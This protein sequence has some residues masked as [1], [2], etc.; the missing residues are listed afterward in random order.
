MS[1]TPSYGDKVSRIGDFIRYPKRVLI[2]A[3]Q[4]GF[5]EEYLFTDTEG[6]RVENPFIY[7]TD[8][9]GETT[10]DSRIEIADTWT[11]ELKETDPRPIITVRRS[12]LSFNR[13]AIGGLGSIDLPGGKWKKFTI[14]MDCPIIAN[15]WSRKDLESEEIAMAVAFFFSLFRETHLKR[16][17]LQSLSEPSIGDTTPVKVDAE[18]ELFVTPVQIMTTMTL[19]W[20]VNY[21][22]L[23][24][25]KGVQINTNESGRS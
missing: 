22:A 1:S 23:A 4:I 21:T 9:N 12:V 16:T 18:H 13:N 5:R 7:K 14:M 17:R 10:K 25:A 24:D 20:K 8:E 2:E 15:C 6:E 19:A 11:E 3:L